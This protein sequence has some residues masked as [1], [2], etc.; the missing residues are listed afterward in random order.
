MSYP[1]KAKDMQ[2]EEVTE[3]LKRYHTGDC[4]TQE[5]A[6]IE[7]WYNFYGTTS[8]LFDAN[9]DLE[10]RKEQIWAAVALS[11]KRKP[12]KFFVLRYAAA[13]IFIIIA[14]L[15]FIFQP[16][17]D[18]GS[19]KDTD[20][21]NDIA[22]GKRGATL[23]LSTGEMIRLTDAARG[24]L[25][26]EAGVVITKSKDGGL[27]YQVTGHSG[28]GIRQMNVLATANGETYQVKLPDGTDIWLNSASSLTYPSSFDKHKERKVKLTGE[29]YFEV[30][31]DKMHSF[32]VETG[33]QRVE[34]LGT[35][36]NINAY[37]DEPVVKTTLLEGSVKV[38]GPN[39]IEKLLK[40]GQ[41]SRLSPAGVDIEDVDTQLA[42][43]WKNNNFIF[44]HD[45]IQ[46]IMRMVARWYNVNVVYDGPI[47]EEQFSGG[48]PRFE[49]VSTI[50]RILEATGKVSFK[51][52]D[53]TIIVTK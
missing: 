11:V 3:I 1:Y 17:G 46:F 26:K 36:F 6:A 42:V 25:A 38:V 7:A 18:F 45:D 43:A 47:P 4:S 32:I 13:A 20:Y 40:P 48:V 27:I 23:T 29:A 37:Q 16:F 14:G 22:A 9:E 44:E 49:N 24:P 19:K 34:V 15:F 33:K 41:Q 53:R 21:A 28:T 10:K 51:I 50:L 5:E 30:A 2:E 8:D 12:F 31:K 35:H 52:E 39:A